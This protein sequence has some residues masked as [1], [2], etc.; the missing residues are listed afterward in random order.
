VDNH[1]TRYTHFLLVWFLSF[2]DFLRPR[3]ALGHF[4]VCSC[5]VSGDSNAHRFFVDVPFC[6]DKGLIFW[7]Y[8]LSYQNHLLPHSLSLKTGV[9]IRAVQVECSAT[10]PE[11][12]PSGLARGQLTGFPTYRGLRRYFLLNSTP[13]SLSGSPTVAYSLYGACWPKTEIPHMIFL[14]LHSGVVASNEER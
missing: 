7:L 12:V 4:L 3:L 1:R 14:R 9:G 10:C 5:L 2:Q 8:A 11:D 13:V 6:Q